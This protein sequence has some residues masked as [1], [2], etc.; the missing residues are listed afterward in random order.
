M[1]LP[2]KT[3]MTTLTLSCYRAQ[4]LKRV[5]AKRLYAWLVSA[6]EWVVPN[7]CLI[8]KLESVAETIGYMGL[9]F[10]VLTFLALVA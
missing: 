4:L 3:W 6:P 10:A 5:R 8:L 9:A 7:A 2:N 1:L